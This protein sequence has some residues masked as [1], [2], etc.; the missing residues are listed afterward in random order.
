MFSFQAPETPRANAPR[1][2]ELLRRL[3]QITQQRYN[4]ERTASTDH[5]KKEPSNTRRPG[6]SRHHSSLINRAETRTQEKHRRSRTVKSDPAPRGDFVDLD[7]IRDTERPQTHTNGGKGRHH[8]FSNGRGGDVEIVGM[9]KSTAHTRDASRKKQT[10]QQLL[11][12]SRGAPSARRNTA[13]SIDLDAIP[14][15]VESGALEVMHPDSTIGGRESTKMVSPSPNSGTRGSARVRTPSV[16]LSSHPGEKVPSMA[17][18]AASKNKQV[19]YCLRIVKEMLRL[20]DAFGF[21]KPIDQLW[22][23]DQLPGYFDIIRNPMDLDTVRRRLESG[24]Y[25]SAPGKQEVEEVTFDADK[26][27]TDMRLIFTNAR[28]YNREGDIFYDAATRLLEKF[29]SKMK[30]LPTVEQLFAQAAKKNKKRKKVVAG[31]PAEGSKRPD[32]TKRRKGSSIAVDGKGISKQSVTKKKGG[33]PSSGKSRS[34]GGGS[35]SRKKDIKAGTA[36]QRDTESMSVVDLESRLRALKRQ[37]V[38]SRAASPASSP[39]AGGGSYMAQAQ[40]LYKVPMTYEEK[41]QLSENV[42]KLPP[43]KLSKIVALATRYKKDSMEVNKNE[44]IELDIDTMNNKTLR[45]MEAYVNQILYR[46]KKGVPGNAA[47]ADIYQM[48]STQLIAEIEKLSSVLR[49]RTKGKS[50]ELANIENKKGEKSFYDS[51]SSSDS[52]DSDGSNSSGYESS[53][54]ESSEDELGADQ[55]RRRR[56]QNLAH[57]AMRAAGTPLPS[58]P[59]H[60][61]GG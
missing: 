42:S 30:T 29:E 17:K 41:V 39:A 34:A 24:F 19:A 44:E 6:T 37:S 61:E 48:S 59:Y 27:S 31:N 46:R 7:L 57:Q 13:I 60:N 5:T 32:A 45:E 49:K 10:G 14:D 51:D 38:L 33:H 36:D 16:L 1:R 2:L 53:S 4:L 58:P 8:A 52:G 47:N 35:L 40:A 18:S 54:E 23:V 20:K 43:D 56:E 22:S 15:D 21:S 9:E 28:S 50:K 26:F 12:S 11:N 3:N 55:M 25:L